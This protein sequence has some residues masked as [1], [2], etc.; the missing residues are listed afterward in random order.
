MWAEPFTEVVVAV[1]QT[2]LNNKNE[3]VGSGYFDAMR[4]IRY[5][6]KNMNNKEITNV[7][8]KKKV[9]ILEL[10][11]GDHCFYSKMHSYL[12]DGEYLPILNPICFTVS[13]SIPI[14]T[15]TWLIGHTMGRN[16]AYAL[17]VGHEENYDE[18]AHKLSIKEFKV[19]KFSKPNKN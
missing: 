2:K 5:R 6:L 16:G 12:N 8:Q 15:G 11:E 17:I 7:R 3:P 1:K 10:S 13:G 19:P 18:I 9:M 4:G 14:N